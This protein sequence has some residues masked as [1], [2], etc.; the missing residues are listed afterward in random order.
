M[1]LKQLH[2]IAYGPFTDCRVDLAPGLNVLYGPNEAGK[3]STLRAVRGLLY[4]IDGRT[5]DNFVHPY[6]QLR[7][8]AT[9]VDERE[10]EF[11]C[12]RRKGNKDTL[13]DGDDTQKLDEAQLRAL[14][15]DVSPE[16]FTTVFGIDH[17]QLREGG[18]EVVRGQ[19]RIG[20]LLFAAAG[21]AHFRTTQTELKESA[22]KLFKKGGSNPKI[23]AA[24]RELTQ[25]NDQIRQ[26]QCPPEQWKTLDQQYADQSE[27]VD[28]LQQQIT[29][30]DAK[31]ER[32]KRI[33]QAL[34]LLTNWKQSR[35]EL[36]KLAAVPRLAGDSEQRFQRANQQR[37]IGADHVTQTKQRLEKIDRQLAGNAVPEALLAQADAIEELYLAY[38][39]HR[40]AMS[41]RP[42]LEAQQRGYR[43]DAKGSIEKLGW[44]ISPDEANEHRLT[45]AQKTR[46]N[47]LIKQHGTIVLAHTQQTKRAERLRR[48]VAEF[49]GDVVNEVPAER[50]HKLKEALQAALPLVVTEQRLPEQRDTVTE[51]A[52]A[53]E[54]KLVRFP[55]FTGTAADVCRMKCPPVETVDRFGDEL[56]AHET[57]CDS[58]SKQVELLEAK[59]EQCRAEL[60]AS[61]R[62]GSVPT[63]ELLQSERDW[64]DRGIRLAVEKLRGASI[65][66]ESLREFVAHVA[67]GEELA[68]ALEPSVAAA[69]EVADRLRREADR[70]AKTSSLLAE[71]AS[72]ERQ[73]QVVINDLTAARA[74]FTQCQSEWVASWHAVG[75]VPGTPGEM[76]GW[77]NQYAAIVALYDD[78]TT[79]REQLER[80][81][82]RIAAPRDRLIESLAA[83]SGEAVGS[84]SL[85]QLTEHAQHELDRFEEVRRD[86]QQRLQLQQRT[87]DELAEAEIE[88]QESQ[89]ELD[90]WRVDWAEAIEPL[91]LPSSALP[92]EAEAVLSLVDEL[93]AKLADIA[94]IR[95]R[96]YGID[97]T[98][99]EFTAAAEQ[100]AQKVA[101]ELTSE[102]VENI[103]TGLNE[104]LGEARRMQ[105]E[106]V[107]LVNRR[108]EEQQSM[109]AAQQALAEAN[110]EIDGM[111]LQAGCHTVDELVAILPQSQQ[112]QRLE[113]I[114]AERETELAAFCAGRSLDE[115][116]A[117]AELED[118][119]KL[120]T[121]LDEFTRQIAEFHD[122]QK[123]AIDARA[124][125]KSQLDKYDGQSV[126]A[127]KLAER[128]FKIAEIEADAR[129]YIVGTI[130]GELLKRTVERY[131]AKAQGPVVLSA[132]GYFRELTCGSFAG[133]R[134][135]VDDKGDVLLGLRS[136]GNTLAIEQM[137]EG[138]RD[139]L[140][141]ALRLA[142]I[143]HWFDSHPPIPFIVDDILLSFDDERAEAAIRTLLRLASQTQVL[144]FTHHEHL[145]SL[146]RRVV[147]ADETSAPIHFVRDWRAS[148]ALT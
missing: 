36:A 61:E 82:E 20:E 112:K 125:A 14:L 124:T 93:Y 12:V 80:A 13:R 53:V 64:R 136:D 30:A 132:S 98:A 78:L 68:D 86:H 103:A 143:E 97:E 18:N 57:R 141:L 134:P 126:A 23:N 116:A 127:D 7:I 76:R 33:Q 49:T 25:I 121:Q 44:K 145:V 11:A 59:R 19:G 137:S 118:P 87:R 52:R 75:I 89:V 77:L 38:G 27:L 46:V 28:K 111:L 47:T 39:S 79:A 114:V 104:R 108:D 95:K 62:T 138:T 9:L 91:R 130:A 71:L 50:P 123:A 69:D 99:K 66:E 70:V 58:L 109:I 48:Q 129:E 115:F 24:I 144:F 45:D 139:Q 60:D 106:H 110:A 56:R 54:N 102:S 101:P 85:A 37:T 4:G 40:K 42:N 26:L 113:I 17:E 96:I 131:Q 84:K 119:D 2:L 51:L 128:Q 41:D 72:I 88:C 133:L 100:L 3:S 16:F 94:A 29:E 22:A 43:A 34:G 55:L 135:D 5:S 107:K 35:A 21:V 10:N 92:S 6:G 32:L 74:R 142:T 117:D 63:E 90:R 140:Y 147:A 148:A 15:G 146:C 120:P 81:N 105:S 1:W 8:G 67:A 73:Q 83:V 31:R 65:D 122:Q